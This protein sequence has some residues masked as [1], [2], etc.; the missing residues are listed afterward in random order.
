MIGQLL[1]VSNFSGIIQ[2][3]GRDFDAVWSAFNEAK[4]NR[5]GGAG[6]QLVILPDA[7]GDG[8]RVEEPLP[9]VTGICVQGMMPV[10]DHS[11]NVPDDQLDPVGGSW[12]EGDGTFPLFQAQDLYGNDLTVAKG[13]VDPNFTTASVKSAHISQI[14]GINFSNVLS[15]GN[16]N[17]CGALYCNLS[18]IYARGC[19]GFG[20]NLTNFMRIFA[21][22]I[23]TIGNAQGQKW[24]MDVPFPSVLQP[25]NSHFIDLFDNIRSDHGYTAAQVRQHQ[26]IVFSAAGGANFNQARGMGIQVNRSGK[27][28]ATYTVDAAGGGTGQ[29][30]LAT[31]TGAELRAGMPIKPTADGGNGNITVGKTMFVYSIVGDVLKVSQTRFGAAVT[32]AISNAFAFTTYGFDG[33]EF[34][35]GTIGTGG[36]AG[37]AGSVTNFFMG[38][39]E[40]ENVCQGALSMENASGCILH[41]TE[42][43]TVASGEQ[44]IVLRTGQPNEIHC[45]K[46][47]STDIDASSVQNLLTGSRDMANSV[48]FTALWGGRNST[49]QCGELGLGSSDLTSG[50]RTSNIQHRAPSGGQYTQPLC[51]FGVRVNGDR[52]GGSWGLNP[53]TGGQGCY[54]G[55]GGTATLPTITSDNAGN[56][57]TSVVGLQFLWLNNGSG[58]LVWAT[59]SG[60][61]FNRASSVESI[62]VPPPVG[63]H[64]SWIE[65][66]AAQDSSGGSTFYHVARWGGLVFKFVSLTF[67]SDANKTLTATESM[68]ETIKFAGGSTLTATRNVVLPHAPGKVW[69]IWNATTGGQSIQAIGASGTGITIGTGKKAFVMSDGTNIERMTADV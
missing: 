6:Q 18:D 58:N 56:A 30:T 47:F 35:G 12:F 41:L 20:I 24:H 4:A 50:G 33:I 49:S 52:G 60:Q 14:C 7:R 44:S 31:G 48:G 11:S 3:K 38:G 26:S 69:C 9:W 5:I 32:G 57:T 39:V 59:A 36:S 66:I 13:S 23:Y 16:T 27:V 28:R 55:S 34:I 10:F 46:P 54:I 51:P 2:A 15:S 43:A 1:N 53:G 45:T 37:T 65:T 63:G 67:S 8:I 22:K 40:S 62:T 64:V 29:V 25:G 68:Y 17:Q 61:P 21:T 19:T 42:F